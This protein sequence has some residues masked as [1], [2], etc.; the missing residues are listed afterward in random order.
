MRFRTISRPISCSLLTAFL[1]LFAFGGMA[2]AEKVSDLPAKPT[3]YVSDYAGVLSEPAKEQL[4]Q[5][6]LQVD[7]QAH[8]QIA[9]V[10]IKTLDG[11]SIEE[12]ANDLF[13]KWGIGAK[14]TDRGVLLL[15][16]IQDRKRRI[17]V[18]FGL[19][20]ILPDGKTGDIGRAM[21]PQL[22]QADYDGAVETATGQIAQVIADDAHVT[23]TGVPAQTE[24]MPQ[25]QRSHGSPVGI[26]IF[27]AILVIVAS[28]G[29]RSGLL[30]FLLGSFLG[31][32]F[33]GGDDRRGG[34]GFG[35]GG[36]GGFGG[37]G[38]GDSGGGG[39][40]GGW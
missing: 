30:W 20:G 33:G 37:F 6:A 28:I 9:I 14:G 35:G 10:T 25:R 17:E 15:L 7:T 26:L 22:Q 31:G 23:L 2:R 29:G 38:G 40:S 3:G 8:A 32:G 39:S 18:G 24:E 27:F 34:G 36:G 16:S 19:E 11:V 1:L 4:E 5:L 12:F 13:H 21:V